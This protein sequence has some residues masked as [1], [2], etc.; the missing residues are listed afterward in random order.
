MTTPTSSAFREPSHTAPV[1]M[2]P[3]REPWADDLA[4]ISR[5]IDELLVSS[6][7]PSTVPVSTSPHRRPRRR[8][9]L[10]PM[11]S[12]SSAS[13]SSASAAQ[14]ASELRPNLAPASSPPL[15]APLLNS[16]TR[17]EQTA[18]ASHYPQL[19]ACVPLQATGAASPRPRPLRAPA[20]PSTPAYTMLSS[21]VHPPQLASPPPPKRMS[22]ARGRSS[23]RGRSP[24]R[25]MTPPVSSPPPLALPAP[26]DAHRAPQLE[27]HLAD[28]PS[29][30][31]SRTRPPTTATSA[32]PGRAQRAP[33]HSR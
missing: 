17:V 29:P 22:P 11:S 13:Y 2:P 32:A 25:A 16:S 28:P 19:S 5:D 26:R 27:H 24:R 1:F 18:R 14:V 4:A 7:L 31:H 33:S 9:S 12:Y 23:S 8:P 15:P 10:D 20:Q 21:F 30:A 6:S 3:P